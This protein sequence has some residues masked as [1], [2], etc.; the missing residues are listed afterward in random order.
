M[1]KP[2]ICVSLIYPKV[3]IEKYDLF[4]SQKPVSECITPAK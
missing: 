3:I 4:G 1:N 2:R